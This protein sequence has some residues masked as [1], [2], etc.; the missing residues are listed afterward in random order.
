MTFVGE[1]Q[2]FVEGRGS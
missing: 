1:E 2:G